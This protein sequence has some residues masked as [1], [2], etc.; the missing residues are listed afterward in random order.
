MHLQ[1]S[2]LCKSECFIGLNIFIYLFQSN[3]RQGWEYK[4][5]C[6]QCARFRVDEELEK[7]P[8]AKI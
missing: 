7:K 1:I 8:R 6:Q 2:G 5:D 4:V 3:Y